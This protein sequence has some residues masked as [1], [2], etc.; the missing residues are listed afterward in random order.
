MGDA[1]LKVYKAWDLPTRIFHWINFSTIT[2]LILFGLL[3]LF[4]KELG[5]T[6]IE[7]KISLKTVHVIIGYVF[8]LNLA[9][10]I[11]WGFIGNH[12]ARWRTVL[13]GRGFMQS[14]H[15][16]RASISAG[17][18][19]QYIGHN[20]LGRLAVC[21][22]LLLM[23]V[24]AFTGLIRA[25]TDIYYPPFG[26]LVADYVAAPGVDPA[27]L[28]PYDPDGMQ[29]SRA[30]QLKAFKEPFGL[31]HLYTA[32]TLMLL[33]VVHIIAVV[34][35]DARHGGSIIS[36]MFTGRKVLSGQPADGGS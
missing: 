36:A 30:E 29:P 27:S 23:L 1:E 22:L 3:M 26:S 17:K 10:R 18:P 5:I 6:S 13:P 31:I 25:A 24:M 4:K 11:V 7:A 14:L 8:V 12:Y 19:Q 2:G 28:I 21:G 32:Y 35:T 16:Y 15:D 34:F 9:F 33:I 20:P